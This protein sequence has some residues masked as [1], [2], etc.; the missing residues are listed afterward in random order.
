MTDIGLHLDL[1]RVGDSV[2]R[3]YSLWTAAVAELRCIRVTSEVEENSALRIS[4]HQLSSLRWQ[5]E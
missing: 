5:N 3:A 2:L 1:E 4:V